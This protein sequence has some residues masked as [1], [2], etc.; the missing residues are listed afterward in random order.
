MMRGAD[1]I[2]RLFQS[3]AQVIMNPVLRD[4]IVTGADGRK[5]IDYAAC[6]TFAIECPPIDT[7]CAPTTREAALPQILLQGP[8]KGAPTL[9]GV[10]FYIG[11]GF[12]TLR[13]VS[14][15]RCSY[16]ITGIN[17]DGLEARLAFLL[18]ARDLFFNDVQLERNPS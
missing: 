9:Q 17:G 5:A 15:K 10:V 1:D 12:I 6:V 4:G 3:A 2:H 11:I 7:P 14:A 13:E 8:F 16:E 18:A